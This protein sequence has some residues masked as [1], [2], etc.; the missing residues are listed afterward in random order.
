MWILAVCL[1]VLAAGVAVGELYARAA[2]ARWL[3]DMADL[4]R[5]GWKTR[6]RIHQLCKPYTYGRNPE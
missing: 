6:A 3:S 1:L 5:D 2:D 4:E